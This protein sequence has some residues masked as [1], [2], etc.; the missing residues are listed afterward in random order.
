MDTVDEFGDVRE[1]WD[2]Y[3]KKKRY[4][5]K[6]LADYEQFDRYLKTMELPRDVTKYASRVDGDFKRL[7]RDLCRAFIAKAAGFDQVL[8]DR[9]VQYKE[10][11]AALKA[12][13][14][15]CKVSDL[16]NAVGSKA[17]PFEPGTTL[18]TGR[19]REALA[20]LKVEHFPELEVDVFFERDEA[21]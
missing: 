9:K 8:A 2:A 21:A 14:I 3:N 18:D 12:C 19:V 5:L 17:K 15:P 6:T 20:K 11:A 4:C 16:D 7:K 1:A 10:F 13:G